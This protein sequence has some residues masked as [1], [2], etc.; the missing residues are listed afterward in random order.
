MGVRPLVSI[1]KYLST[2]YSPDVD[3]VDGVIEDRNVGER[4]HSL[5][6]QRLIFELGKFSQVQV[7][8]SQHVQVSLTRWR[9]PDICVTLQEPDEQIFTT[10]P[11]LCI[12]ILSSRDTMYRIVR[13]L[14]DYREFGAPHIWLVDPWNR[15]TYTYSSVGLVEVNAETLATDDPRIVVDLCSLYEGLA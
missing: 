13:K 10:P 14:H 3:Y 8:P 1:K 5:M 6:Q 9:V 4:W 11:F 7:W 12:E 15:K 2:G